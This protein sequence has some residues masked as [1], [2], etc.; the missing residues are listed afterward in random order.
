MLNKE[1][2]EWFKKQVETSWNGVSAAFEKAGI[3][4]TDAQTNKAWWFSASDKDLEAFITP[5]VWG[6]LGW[7]DSWADGSW[8]KESGWKDKE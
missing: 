6:F 7:K 4:P 8:K 5:K 2:K 1:M 3:K